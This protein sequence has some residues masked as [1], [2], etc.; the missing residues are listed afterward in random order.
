M[1]QIIRAGRGIDQANT[2]LPTRPTDIVPYGAPWETKPAYI[3]STQEVIVKRIS[4]E[5]EEDG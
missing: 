3:N 1:I 5:D 2:A 4:P